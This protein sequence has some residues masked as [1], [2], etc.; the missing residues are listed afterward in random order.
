MFDLFGDLEI[1]LQL[2]RLVATGEPAD[3]DSVPCLA[4]DFRA[5]D[6]GIIALHLE[7]ARQR[8]RLFIGDERCNLYDPNLSCWFNRRRGVGCVWA[9][10][11]IGFNRI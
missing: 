5:C 8:L 9:S 4:A 3:F 2:S 7:L 10:G 1:F 6:I 11:S